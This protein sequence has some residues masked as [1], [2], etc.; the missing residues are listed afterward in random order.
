MSSREELM[1]SIHPGMKLNKAF[2]LNIYGYAISSPCFADEAIQALNDAGCNRAREYYDK[3]VSEYK[4][5][6]DEALKKVVAWYGKECEKE[7]M[8]RGEVK[9][10]QKKQSRSEMWAELSQIL[11]FQQMRMEK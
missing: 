1:R 9:R 3:V 7:W 4:K 2:F 5:N 6:H 11:G 8:K 10:K